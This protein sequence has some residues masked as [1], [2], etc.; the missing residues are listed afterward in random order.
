MS[1]E[2]QGWSTSI[3]LIRSIQADQSDAWQRFAHVYTPLIYA[4]C[5]Q[6]KLQPA[7][8]ADI[9]QE[10]FRKVNA[11]VARLQVGG[12]ND[13]FRGWLWTITRHE[14]GRFVRSQQERAVATGGSDAQR[15]LLQVLDWVNDE[16]V[17]E[18]EDAELLVVR[19]ATELVRG[20]FQEQTWLTWSTTT[21]RR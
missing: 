1:I 7:D 12:P 11:G 5:R 10:I 8:A 13:S 4:W 6:A 18:V 3:G 21:T 17:P 14:I 19:R 20:D 9:T 15:R 16:E 2:S